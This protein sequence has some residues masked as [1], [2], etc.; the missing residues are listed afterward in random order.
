[1]HTPSADLSFV[2][3]VVGMAWL[4]CLSQCR[5]GPHG[6][7]VRIQNLAAAGELDAAMAAD[8]IQRLGEM[9]RSM[10]RADKVSAPT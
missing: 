10:G 7:A 5:L 1:M 4:L 9:R 6:H 2:V 3:V 8:I